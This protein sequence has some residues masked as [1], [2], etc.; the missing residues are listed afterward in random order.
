MQIRE[1]RIRRGITQAELAEKT[2]VSSATVIRWENGGPEP[3]ASELI[4]MSRFFGCSA[5][6][7]LQEPNPPL[8]RRKRMPGRLIK[9]P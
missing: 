8:P 4:A 2:G 9:T 5:D 6:E 3:R 7:I 1:L